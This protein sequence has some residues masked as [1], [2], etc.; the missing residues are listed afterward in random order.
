MSDFI[1]N[2]INRAFAYDPVIHPRPRAYY[3]PTHSE[4][5]TAFVSVI[6]SPRQRGGPD[7]A[8][9]DEGRKTSDLLNRSELLPSSEYI[10]AKKQTVLTTRHVEKANATLSFP[11]SKNQRVSPKLEDSFER[12]RAEGSKAFSSNIDSSEEPASTEQEKTDDAFAKSD[13]LNQSQ[14]VGSTS[15]VKGPE[16]PLFTADIED[17]T[18]PILRSPES[19][20]LPS[21]PI[22]KEPQELKPVNSFSPKVET[23]VQVD[24]HPEAEKNPTTG[25]VSDA[26]LASESEAKDPL[27]ALDAERKQS[28]ATFEF[29]CFKEEGST[30]STKRNATT[31]ESAKN[32]VG[33]ATAETP[34]EVPSTEESLRRTLEIEQRPATA[35]IKSEKKA[36]RNS[37][38]SVTHP[39]KTEVTKDVEL[40]IKRRN[41]PDTPLVDKEFR[42]RETDET[43]ESVLPSRNENVRRKP[44]IAQTTNATLASEQ[45]TSKSIAHIID[46]RNRNES[47]PDNRDKQEV[48]IGQRVSRLSAGEQKAP[49]KKNAETQPSISTP[50]SESARRPFSADS[51]KNARSVSARERPDSTR[52][53]LAITP[54]NDFDALPNIADK[55]ESQETLAIPIGK[56]TRLPPEKG[57]IEEKETAANSASHPLGHRG[58]LVRPAST[59]EIRPMP[60]RHEE[61]TTKQEP[62]IHVSIGRI[63]VKA[64]VPQTPAPQRKANTKPATM[65]LDDYLMKRNGRVK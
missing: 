33:N 26:K 22:V 35:P 17:E 28:G 44:G 59:E 63:E 45:Q 52:P 62:T 23:A 25:L 11:E 57:A 34:S 42:T 15:Y 36:F 31:C 47:R 14:L 43:R 64:V 41:V 39:L 40:T 53:H 2:L 13:L 24:W 7:N 54:T 8:N 51:S 65:S 10:D 58:L 5:E 4:E 6:E 38:P 61:P 29:N 18:K 12:S 9:I 20:I 1:D 37:L 46:T 48:H 27:A 32:N 3:E 60:Y 16:Q 21:S 50:R 30:G 49:L 55:T 19:Q 56:S